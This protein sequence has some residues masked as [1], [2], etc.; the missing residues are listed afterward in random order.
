[1]RGGGGGGGGGREKEGGTEYSVNRGR[2][3]I[4]II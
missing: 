2:A 1:M 3:L 4:I